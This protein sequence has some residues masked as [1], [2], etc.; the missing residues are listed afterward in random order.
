MPLPRPNSPD[1]DRLVVF[2]AVG[3]SMLVIG[4]LWL[5][6]LPG[7][8]QLTDQDTQA[9]PLWEKLR[10]DGE[11]TVAAWTE[12]V[13]QVNGQVEQLPSDESLFDAPFFAPQDDSGVPVPGGDTAATSEAATTPDTAV[14]ATD[15]LNSEEI[16]RFRDKLEAVPDQS[17][18]T[19]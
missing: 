14:P 18:F 4:G 13:Q 19:Q 2:G 16:D 15:D 17:D 6:L 10:Q 1:K 3:L 12:T 11:D 7:Q 9:S 5:Y 8:L